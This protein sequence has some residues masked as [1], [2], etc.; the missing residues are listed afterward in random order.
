[1][2]G[3]EGVAQV[4]AVGNEAASYF[5]PGDWVLPATPAFGM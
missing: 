1:V 4:I 5:T 2:A 3:N